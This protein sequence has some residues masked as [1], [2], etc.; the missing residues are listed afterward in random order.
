MEIAQINYL[1]D[2][3]TESMHL[4]SKKT[5]ITDAPT[6]NQGKGEAFSPTDL[7]CNALAACALTIMGIAAKNHNINMDNTQ[8]SISKFMLADPRRV[9]KIVLD[10][11]FPK[12][13][14]TQKEKSILENAAKTCPVAKSLSS[15]LIQEFNFNY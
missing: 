13:T 9:G 6:D 12:N 2:L 14:Y 1:G 7:L 4:K 10:F 11:K 5:V 8:V 3:R 15:D